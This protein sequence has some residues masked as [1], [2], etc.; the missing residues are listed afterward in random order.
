[1]R[2]AL[3]TTLESEDGKILN[4]ESPLRNRLWC[5]LITDSSE[6]CQ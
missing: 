5:D 2:S 6:S 4:K 1:V 3:E